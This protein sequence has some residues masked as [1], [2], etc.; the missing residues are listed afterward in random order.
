MFCTLFFF[1]LNKQTIITALISKGI[2]SVFFFFF[3]HDDKFT[4]C[5]WKQSESNLLFNHFY[6]RF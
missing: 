1:I 6:E 4:F 3:G 5:V 2:K